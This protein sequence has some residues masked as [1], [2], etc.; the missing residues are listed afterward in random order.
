MVLI[1]KL[2]NQQTL[3]YNLRVTNLL[4][5]NSYLKEKSFVF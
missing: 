4:R 1:R 3:I 5:K 2:L